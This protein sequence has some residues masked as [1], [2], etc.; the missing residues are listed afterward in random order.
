MIWVP[1]GLVLY[2]NLVRLPPVYC[3][4]SIGIPFV[5][6][7]FEKGSDCCGKPETET[8]NSAIPFK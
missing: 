5:V 1:F 8:G 7:K 4:K 6:D 2:E 3:C